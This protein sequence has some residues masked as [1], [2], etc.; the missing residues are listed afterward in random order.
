[1][2]IRHAICACLSVLCICCFLLVGTSSASAAEYHAVSSGSWSEGDYSGTWNVQPTMSHV[3]GKAYGTSSYCKAVQDR[4][5][6]SEMRV[7]A[8][9]MCTVTV[10]GSP[11]AQYDYIVYYR[12]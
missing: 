9:A 1:M 2:H 5:N 8:G 4:T 11:N 3:H 7:P 12:V 6:V 10:N